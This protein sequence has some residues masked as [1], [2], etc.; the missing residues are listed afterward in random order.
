MTVTPK[1]L[2][3]NRANAKKS[4]GPRTPAGKSRSSMNALKH[5]LFSARIVL[6]HEDS[7]EFLKTRERMLRKLKPLDLAETMLCEAMIYLAWRTSRLARLPRPVNATAAKQFIRCEQRLMSELDR[8]VNDF[9]K[10][11][12]RSRSREVVGMSQA[13]SPSGDAR[14][15]AT[16]R[17][18]IS[19]RF[20]QDEPKQV[21]PISP[22]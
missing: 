9:V 20:G 1:K 5:G 15:R 22:A 18:D 13:E 3:A 14:D 6:P 10:C 16:K 19:H 21:E 17:I 11:R 8:T 4:T 12:A 7:A 2:A